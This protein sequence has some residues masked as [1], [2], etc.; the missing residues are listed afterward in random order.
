[1]ARFK[2][3]KLCIFRFFYRTGQI[4]P[5]VFLLPLSIP[6]PSTV[7][8]PPPNTFLQLGASA[9]GRR[10]THLR[11]PLGCHGNSHSASSCLCR[12]WHCTVERS[13]ETFKR[14]EKKAE[15]LQRRRSNLSPRAKT[16]LSLV[17]LVGEDFDPRGRGMAAGTLGQFT[18][19]QRG[20]HTQPFMQ[21]LT[22]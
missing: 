14:G 19:L 17:A 16:P 22:K 1:M 15:N 7:H 10:P 8:T 13:R 21:R 11:R 6:T 3:T 18:V 5:C 4:P 20:R 2:W 9:S 12:S